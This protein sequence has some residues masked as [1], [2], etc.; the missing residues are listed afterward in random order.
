MKLKELKQKEEKDLKE[1][2]PQYRNKL[3]ELRF[4]IA[5]RKLRNVKEIQEVKKTIARILTLLKK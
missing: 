5:N 1:L 3:R 4:D 2:L